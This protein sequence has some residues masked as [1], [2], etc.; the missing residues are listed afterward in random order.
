VPSRRTVALATVP[1]VLAAACAALLLA[2]PVELRTSLYDLAGEG[3]RA[4]PE[5]V[6]EASADLV[7][8]LV[9]SAD[10][11]AARAAAETIAKNL[12]EEFLARADDPLDALASDRYGLASLDDVRLLRT[13]EGRAKIARRALRRHV[14][15]PLPPFFPVAEDPFLLA[16]GYVRSLFPGQG[17]WALEEGAGA[18]PILSGDDGRG[19][20]RFMLP[21]RVA[22]GS[23][24]GRLVELREALLPVLARSCGDGVSAVAC[25]VP[26][27]TA[28]A[29]GNCRRQVD[30]LSAFSLVFIAALAAFVLRGLR[31]MAVV[32]SSLAVAALAGGL[33]LVALFR[34][35]HVMALVF[36]TTVLGLTVDYSFHRLMGRGVGRELAVSCLTTEIAL[37]PLALS[38]LPVL[39]Q[40]AAFLGAG[41][42]AA[43]A[44]VLVC[45]PDG[46]A[47]ASGQAQGGGRF[48]TVC[49]VLCV[50]A[51]MAAGVGLFRAEVGTDLAALYRPPAELA[52]AER[53]IA[54][55]G[56]AA[57]SDRGFL[58]FERDAVA[59]DV[60]RLFDE[61]GAAL[62]D[63]LGIERL[64]P[65]AKGREREYAV[66]SAPVDGELPRGV[67]F[68]RPPA[69]RLARTM[70][71]WTRRTEL[72]LAAALPLMLLALVA[73]FRRRAFGMFVPSLFALAAAAGF[74]SLLGE[75][76]NLFH[77]L[78]GFLLA[79]MTVDYA[80]FLRSGRDGAF[81]PAFCSL[82]TSVAGFG[83]LAFVS[84]PPVRSFGVVLGLGLPAGF[85]FACATAPKGRAAA[86][87]GEGVELAASPLG[88]ETLWI[89]Y[90][91]FGLGALHLFAACVGLCAW[92]FSP[93]V[94]RATPLGK[95][96]NFTR[97]LA[98]KLVVMA[99]GKDLP[100]VETDGSAD[101]AAFL[102]DV[103]SGRGVFVL[104]SH[105]GTVEALAA[106]GE[107]DFAFH[108]WMD[109]DRTSVFNRFYM[110]HAARSKVS[111]HPISEVGM[112]TA[113]FAGDALERG[114]C[115]VMAGD[116]GRGAFRFAHALAANAYF[117]ACV[118]NGRGYT[119][120]VRRLPS[121]AVEM[122]AAYM[123]HLGELSERYPEQCFEWN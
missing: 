9:S 90:R 8:V 64:A 117:V 82:L 105:C 116:R 73:F 62:A 83:A 66:S 27:H 47:V 36:G 84:F 96:V 30:A 74:V 57:G 55:I 93:R 3:A 7:P 71:E 6:R 89:L 42:A 118:W 32:A 61:H 52:E 110:R 15:S 86:T 37:L 11:E 58:V 98:D 91:I 51:A 97:S 50:V 119:A 114:D 121:G 78:A 63:K 23:G 41:L 4:I 29:A 19:K 111:I 34:E 44:Y 123:R 109:Y 26:M 14:S 10:R 22:Q 67:S 70:S 5:S 103:S 122:E 24:T 25:G 92:T 13:A 99:D 81:R 65:P 94:R 54:E 80:I 120:V 87:E 68:C 38:G 85:L 77:L 56:G 59:A 45:H 88:L 112:A 76:I 43:L 95:L 104:S 72:R 102:D 101:A 1:L 31:P 2:R 40:A 33:V 46:S 113:F 60:A 79:G 106:L 20:F 75:K 107:C 35:V 48:R 115:L 12:P 100:R 69:E 28:V 39:R 17:G 53:A 49:R 16:D 21:L 108:A 18:H